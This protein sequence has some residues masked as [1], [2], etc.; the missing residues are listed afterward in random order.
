MVVTPA[1]RAV[2]QQRLQA[3]AAQLAARQ[4]E[5]RG[6]AMQAANVLQRC[7]PALEG[8]WL[9]GSLPEGRFGLQ[10]DVDLAVAGLP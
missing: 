6:L 1:Q 7:W 9:F 2:W 5:A 4:L 8:V 10:S 3:E